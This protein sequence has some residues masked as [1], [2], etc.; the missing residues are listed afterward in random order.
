MYSASV[1]A[2]EKGNVYVPIRSVTI[3]VAPN[4]SRQ[5][6][7]ESLYQTVGAGVVWC[8][9]GFV[10]VK[11]STYFTKQRTLKGPPL[12]GM[13]LQWSKQSHV[14]ESAR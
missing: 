6:A 8:G 7:I 13:D 10:D 9:A 11:K 14:Q 4:E 12:I 5:R 1:R 2:S 3:Q